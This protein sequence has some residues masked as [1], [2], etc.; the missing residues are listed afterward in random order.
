M[1]ILERPNKKN[2]LYPYIAFAAAVLFFSAAT[3]CGNKGSE[4]EE[5]YL[6]KVG[7]HILTV[8]DYNSALEIAK[9]AYPHNQVQGSDVAKSIMVRLLNQMIEEMV[10]MIKAS[11]LG[12]HI[13]EEEMDTA[14][15]AIR[16]D[17]PEDEFEKTFLE[18]AISFESWKNR[19]KARLLIEKVVREELQNKITIGPDDISNYY[20]ANYKEDVSESNS[21]GDLADIDKE[22]IEDIRRKKAEE[23]YRDWI[24]NLQKKYTIDINTKIWNKMIGS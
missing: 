8:S 20:K 10:I 7:K 11:E 14:V 6:V 19:L 17:Y 21:N 1:F 5:A 13:S 3:G 24:E 16:E 12:I 4:K 15:S 9:T 18:N 22:I 2:N 23:M